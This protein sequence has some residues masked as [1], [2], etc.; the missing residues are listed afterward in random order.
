MTNDVKNPSVEVH[1]LLWLQ[2]SVQANCCC[3]CCFSEAFSTWTFTL[4]WTA[5]KIYSSGTKGAMISIFGDQ[6]KS[7]PGREL[8]DI[9]VDNKNLGR[10]VTSVS[11]YEVVAFKS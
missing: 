10:G 9:S 6:S 3:C 8:E 5:Q 1:S 4:D 11:R 7:I 2:F